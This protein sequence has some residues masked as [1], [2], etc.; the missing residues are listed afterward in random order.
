MKVSREELLRRAAEKIRREKKAK[1]SNGKILLKGFS[2]RE[3]KA[4]RKKFRYVKV[5]N[6]ELE[7]YVYCALSFY[8]ELKNKRITFKHM[9]FGLFSHPVLMAAARFK[10]LS[11]ITGKRHYVVFLNKKYSKNLLKEFSFHSTVYLFAHELSHIV[12][13][14]QKNRKALV[15]FGARYVLANHRRLSE[16]ETDARVVHRGLGKHMARYLDELRCSRKV[17]KRF[18]RY[19]HSIYMRKDDLKRLRN[20]EK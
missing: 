16:F 18:K 2:S 15:K 1:P 4:L 13:Y 17:P 9:N 20:K 7:K 3:M 8:P 12:D 6:K 19:R 10:I 5:K 11:V 14:E